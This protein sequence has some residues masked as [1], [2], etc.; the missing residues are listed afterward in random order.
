[1]K[2]L[3]VEDDES[4]ANMVKIGLSADSH[5]VEIAKDGADGSFLARSY[6]YDIIILDYSLPKKD[7]LCVCREIR[8]AGKTAPIIF[9]SVTMDTSVKVNAFN[10]GADDYVTKPFSI[11]ELRARVKALTRRP[12]TVK[13]P[14]ITI[15]DLKLDTEKLMASRSEKPIRLTRKEFSLLEYFM[16]NVG[17]VLSRAMILEHVWT[18]ESDPLSNTVE[19][20]IRNLRKKLNIKNKPDLIANIQGRGYVIDSPENIKK[21][22][23]S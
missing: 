17:I 6:D 21:L 12:H 10:F 5:L 18:A 3:I 16:K 14:V 11:E 1:M 9:L 20:H 2:I 4:V 8:A 22:L 19:A 7:G 13:D 23:F 15:S